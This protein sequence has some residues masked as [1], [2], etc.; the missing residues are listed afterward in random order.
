MFE[1]CFT[2]KK[3]KYFEKE[4]V[5]VAELNLAALLVFDCQLPWILLS[6]KITHSMLLWDVAVK[7]CID[8][9]LVVSV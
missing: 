2:N 4:I 8:V 7:C 5:T 1:F 3:A 9:G 6:C